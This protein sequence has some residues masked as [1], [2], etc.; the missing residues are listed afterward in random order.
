M[1][2]ESVLR[3]GVWIRHGCNN[4]GGT[5]PVSTPMAFWLQRDVLHYIKSNGLEIAPVYGDIIV[6]DK[7]HCLV[8]TGCKRTG[9]FA[10]G[11]GA[12]RRGDRRLYDVFEQGGDNLGDWLLRGGTF[13]DEG[14]WI[15]QG[16][17]GMAF[18]YAWMNSH[19]GYS[20]PIPFEDKYIGQLPDRAKELL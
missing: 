1:A 13:D 5:H 2:D 12:H 19:G 6:D 4:F 9:C 7:K 18:V 3:K 10:C 14:M 11:F 17:M 16:G 15:P 20:I 8:T